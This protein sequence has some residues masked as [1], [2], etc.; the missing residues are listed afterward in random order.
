MKVTNFN[1]LETLVKRASV[2][3]KSISDKELYRKFVKE[4]VDE[5]TAYMAVKM[6]KQLNDKLRN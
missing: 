5:I 3:T 4:G 6:S 2:L 1:N